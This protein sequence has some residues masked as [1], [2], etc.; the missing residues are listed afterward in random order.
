VLNDDGSIDNIGY[1]G[2]VNDWRY[3]VNDN[4]CRI[5]NWRL[6]SGPLRFR[7]SWSLDRSWRSLN[8]DGN[9]NLSESWK[10]DFQHLSDPETG[11]LCSRCIEVDVT[12]WL[13]NVLSNIA[14]CVQ[15]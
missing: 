5:R 14:L 11:D 13:E 15:Q 2:S 4:W 3:F 10:H 8:L 1:Q 6:N 7:G 12:S 9:W